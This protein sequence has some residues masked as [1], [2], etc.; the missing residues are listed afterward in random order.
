MPPQL[1]QTRE[2]LIGILQEIAARAGTRV[3]LTLEDTRPY[4]APA[5]LA[6]N[7]FNILPRSMSDPSTGEET[8]DIYLGVAIT[9]GTQEQVIPFFDPGLSPEYEMTRA[10][11]VVSHPTRKRLGII[12]TD[13]MMLGGV[14]FRTNEPRPTWAAVQEL[15]KQYDVVEVTPASAAESQVDL[16]L[17]ALPSRMTQTDLDLA[18]EPTRRGIPTLLLVDPLPAIDLNLA[19]AADL[20]TEVDPYRQQAATRLVYGNIRGALAQLGIN[21]VP[22]LV[23]WD[24]FNPH[25]DLAELPRETVFVTS[26]NGNV[27]AINRS[28]PATAR[29]QE[30]LLLYPGYLSPS[31]APGLTLEPLLQTGRVSGASSFFDL[32]RPTPGG[33]ALVPAPEREPDGRQYVLAAHVTS[34]APVSDRAGAKPLNVIAVADI[35]FISDAIFGIRATAGAN[36][37]FDNVTFFLNAVDQLANER[38]YVTLRSRQLRYRTLERV[39]AQTRTFMQRR[40]QQE[41]QAQA[42]ARTALEEARSRLERR[43]EE[44]NARTDLDLIAR[45]ILVRNV[46]ETENRRLRVLETNIAQARDI[47]ITASREDMEAEVRRIRTRIRAL[48]LLVPPLP[49][50]AL[51]GWVFLRRKRRERN[52]TAATGRLRASA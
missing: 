12:D 30:V 25:P 8:Q 39:E 11:Q 5:T 16:L 31:N 43:T 22:A 21:W 13:V 2:N 37:R 15:R 24:G 51:G 40:A 49:V 44:L 50:L 20:A 33:L 6:R 4:S 3:T 14:D 28:N 41:Q 18:M 17:V 35:D 27:N 23:A 36:A 52:S 29:L 19:P 32:V 1:V 45:Q 26:G 42:E 34:Q 46:E 38:S 7:R 10:I 9:S 47:K 48:A